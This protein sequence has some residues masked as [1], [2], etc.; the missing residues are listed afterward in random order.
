MNENIIA[1]GVLKG[2]LYVLL[3]SLF[4]YSI[5]LL[6]SI[7]LYVF[8]AAVVSLIGRPF[9]I[10]F[11]KKLKFNKN[12][13]SIFTVSFIILLTLGFFSLLVP[14]IVQQ[15]ENLSLLDINLLEKRINKLFN[16]IAI[17]ID[18][19][20]SNINDL[21]TNLNLFEFLNLSYIP[22]FLNNFVDILGGF[23][24]GLFSIIFISFFF[25]K[26]SDL[27]ENSVFFFFNKKTHSKLKKSFEEIKDLLSRYFIGL[28][29]QISILFLIY[30]AFLLIFQI[31]N[32]LII[33]FLCAILNLIPY[34]GP[35][36]SGFL[37]LILCMTSN[38]DQ[39]FSSIVVPNT[40]YVMIGFI[41]GQLIDNFFS[42]PFIF[43]KSVKSHPL[44]IFIVIIIS[45][46]L[47]GLM[48]LVFAIPFYTSLKVIFKEFYSKNF[49]F[50]S[51]TI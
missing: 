6:K 41:V 26:D 8:L 32:A 20:K 45:G 39:D 19:N 16:E 47:F 46:T 31:K 25:L 37:M 17:Y 12:I 13:A 10:F 5:Y 34:V 18:L 24:I 15:T 29:I 36:I 48:G 30:G 3:L 22:I 23:A 1:K 42:Q 27:L 4:L 44:E 35:L 9:V 43:S 38:L 14:L 7:I 50:K 2:A 33:A 11:V 21:L 40:I 49:S 51:L 28:I